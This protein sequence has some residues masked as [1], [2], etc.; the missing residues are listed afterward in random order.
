MLSPSFCGSGVQEGLAG[1]FW[2]GVL[3]WGCSQ[4]VAGAAGGWLGCPPPN[5]TSAGWASSQHGGPGL[6]LRVL[7]PA[8]EVISTVTSA[9]LYQSKRSREADPLSGG[10]RVDPVSQWEHVRGA[11]DSEPSQPPTLLS[12][13]SHRHMGLRYLD[14]TL[15]G[16]IPFIY[17]TY[18]YFLE[19]RCRDLSELYPSIHCTFVSI[20]SCSGSHSFI[21]SFF[22]CP[23]APILIFCLTFHKQPFSSTLFVCVLTSMYFN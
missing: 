23:H 3:S 11:P 16:S 2:L 1:L 4:A 9:E 14:V 15:L 17:Q 10:G 7:D 13:N 18:F 22:F 20:D 12:N 6:V 5:P 21:H 19:L 8:L